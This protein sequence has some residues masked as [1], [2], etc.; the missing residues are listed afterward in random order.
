MV[1]NGD[2]QTAYFPGWDVPA[3]V[4]PGQRFVDM[5][6]AKGVWRHWYDFLCDL[7][8][9][10]WIGRMAAQAQEINRSESIWK[11]VMYFGLHHWSLPYEEVRNHKFTVPERHRWGAWG[12]QRGIDLARL[13][14]HPDIDILV[15]ETFPP[16]AAHL[17]GY[18][19]EYARITREAKKT[20]GV[21]LHRDDHW[22]LNIEEEAKRWAIINQ[23]QPMVVTRLPLAG[24]LPGDE[25]YNAAAEAVFSKGLTQYRKCHRDAPRLGVAAEHNV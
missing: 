2:G 12:R 4:L 22:P 24:M 11:G 10:N 14:A 7:L 6:R 5:P 17:E 25:R 18:I 13:A 16:V 20:Y 8:L 19:A 21:M 9:K 23:Y 1:A 15:C 3:K